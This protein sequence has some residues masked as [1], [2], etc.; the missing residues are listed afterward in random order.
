MH[1][2]SFCSLI[3]EGENQRRER[4]VDAFIYHFTLQINSN[5]SY[6]QEPGIQSVSSTWVAGAQSLLPSL[7]S[8]LAEV[9]KS[10][11]K[12]NLGTLT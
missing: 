6:S 5:Q 7:T 10:S 11:P 3:R 1:L 9:W 12:L 4:H 8:A 2:C